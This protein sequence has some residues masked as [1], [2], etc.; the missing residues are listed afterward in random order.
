MSISIESRLILG[1]TYV[2]CVFE[3]KTVG[4]TTN[5]VGK[6]GTRE[7]GRRIDFLGVKRLLDDRR[8]L[9]IPWIFAGSSGGVAE[10]R[11]RDPHRQVNV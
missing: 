1:T 7:D 3:S 5:A 8:F 10:V 4:R 2:R 11:D 6:I 9:G